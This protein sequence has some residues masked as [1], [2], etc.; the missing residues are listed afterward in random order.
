[1]SRS[2]TY[3]DRFWNKVHITEDGC[4]VWMASKMT[5]GYG[6]FSFGHSRHVPAHRM[7]F[8]L[9]RGRW[10]NPGLFVCHHCDNR[11]CV[12]PSHLFEG[13]PKDNIQ[14]ACKKGRMN[15]P[16]PKAAGHLN[17]QAKLT[18]DTVRAIRAERSGVG[19]SFSKLAKKHG[20]SKKNVFEIVHNRSWIV[21]NGL[22]DQTPYNQ[23]GIAG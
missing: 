20:C 21:T 4:W 17:H 10:P 5:E 16:H 15:K 13:T 6:K 3:G 23:S 8:F 2:I 19:T 14:D 9:S 22:A 12:N 1:M 18:W 7:A 11:A